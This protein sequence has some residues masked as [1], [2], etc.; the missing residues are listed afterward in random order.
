[1]D[2]LEHSPKDV[3]S[4]VCPHC[5]IEMHLYRS[6]LVRFVPTVDLLLYECPTCLVFAE[7]EVAR[8]PVWVPLK[9]SVNCVRFF[10]T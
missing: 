1:M 8:E 10:S 3:E 6:E 7:S 5:G 4:P 2:Q 9:N